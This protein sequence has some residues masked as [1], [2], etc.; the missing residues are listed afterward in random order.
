MRR[1]SFNVGDRA[2]RHDKYASSAVNGGERSKS[3]GSTTPEIAE[4]GV[5]PARTF[6]VN[7]GTLWPILMSAATAARY[8]GERSA[9]AFRKKV[10]QVYPLPAAHFPGR[11]D[12]WRKAD[13][14]RFAE[15]LSGRGAPH[16]AADIL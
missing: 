15:G 2:L 8:V 11:G 12:I 10:G 16:D 14:D 9:K 13:L 1:N 4:G 7:E 6:H 5:A 3:V